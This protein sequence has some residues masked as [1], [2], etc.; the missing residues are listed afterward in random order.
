[1]DLTNCFLVAAIFSTSAMAQTKE[2]GYVADAQPAWVFLDGT[3]AKFP[4]PVMPGQ[5]L[6]PM[7]NGASLIT[8]AYLDGKL[9]TLHCVQSPC[10]YHVKTVQPQSS[11][12]EFLVALRN[13]FTHRDVPSIPAVTRGENALRPQVLPLIET[14]LSLEDAVTGLDPGL[15]QLKFKPLHSVSPQGTV[16]N[17]SVSWDAPK[18]TVANVP[19]LM[20]GLYELSLAA[21]DGRTMGRRVV[22]VL[23]PADFAAKSET[24]NRTRDFLNSQID[25]N[26]IATPN[27]LNALLLKL[28]N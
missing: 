9:D 4:S 19:G 10:E 13:L 25:A 2:A 14:K 16:V 18:R 12:P 23:V 26:P 28:G 20:P 11:L 8:I 15:Y 7:G 27:T 21:D 5:V 1:M 24:F 6:H 3:P 17:G 22:L